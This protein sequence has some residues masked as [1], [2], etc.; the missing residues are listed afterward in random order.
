VDS[1]VPDEVRPHLLAVL[2]GA[3]TNAARHAKA[4]SV[5]VSL[6]VG[7]EV[8]LTVTDDGVGIPADVRMSGLRNMA[9]RAASAGGRCELVARP[10]GGTTVRWSV[11]VE[12]P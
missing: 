12:R 3:L 10:G 5:D 1:A 4:S 2:R 6:A 11:P 8:V 7:D 9:D